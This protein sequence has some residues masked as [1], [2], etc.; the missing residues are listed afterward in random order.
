MVIELIAVEYGWPLGVVDERQ[1]SCF[2]GEG[3]TGVIDFLVPDYYSYDWIPLESALLLP[4][5]RV[6]VTWSDGHELECHPLWLREN[7]PGP[8]G[9]DPRSK[10]NDLDVAKLNLDTQIKTI[11]VEDG[12]LVVEFSPEGRKASFHPGWLRHVADGDHH[13]F[14]LLPDL[15]VWKSRDLPEPPTH[16][17]PLVLENDDAFASW[18]D[19]L[20]KYGLARLVSLPVEDGVIEL[21]GRR[22]GVLRDSNFG[23]TW[24]VSVDLDPNSTANT[25][26]ELPAHSDLPSRETPPG[27]QLLHCQENTVSGGQS[28][29]T[30]GLAVTRYLEEHEPEVMESLINDEW[31]FFNRDDQ[32]DH[33]W[34]GPM[35]D[36]GDGRVPWTFRAFHPVRGFPA[37][38]SERINDAYFAMQRF[39]QVANSSDFQIRYD[40]NPGD[41]VAFDNRRVLHGRKSF[42]SS[43]G[44][45]RLRGTYIDSDEVYSRMRVLRHFIHEPG[46]SLAFSAARKD[47]N[48]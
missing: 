3:R 29:M 35:I 47:S 17:G 39:G 44:S 33:R 15:F 20:L 7:S 9:I 42:E 43:N 22:I 26:I 11:S 21:I 19:D 48:A 28:T 4:T 38:P 36:K 25:A 18:L 16:L 1:V 2:R 27:F 32:H 46:H 37:M 13:P 6:V 41:L 10:E 31:V 34:T 8:G 30:D 23:A 5:G 14:A 12:G 45:R 24:H 40:L